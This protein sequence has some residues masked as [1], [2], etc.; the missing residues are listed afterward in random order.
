MPL[1]SL[2]SVGR[3]GDSRLGARRDEEAPTP[4]EVSVQVD[5]SSSNQAAAEY[6]AQ[7]PNQLAKIRSAYIFQ[8]HY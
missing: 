3:S 7:Y 8:Y 1:Q 6:S 2:R 4:K 5:V